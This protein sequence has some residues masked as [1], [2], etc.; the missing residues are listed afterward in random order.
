MVRPREMSVVR[1][2]AALRAAPLPVVGR[3]TQDALQLDVLALDPDELP[4]V[5]DTVARALLSAAGSGSPDR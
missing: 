3:V 2:E 1:L 4:L 5:A